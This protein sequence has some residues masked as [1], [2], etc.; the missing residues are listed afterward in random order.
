MGHFCLNNGLGLRDTL[1]RL[2]TLVIRREK[3]FRTHTEL[4]Y[5]HLLPFL[6][7]FGHSSRGPC[8]PLIQPSSRHGLHLCSG[9]ATFPNKQH[10][11]PGICT[12]P[13][14]QGIVLHGTRE[15][16]TCRG[17]EAAVPVS[18]TQLCLKKTQKLQNPAHRPLQE[19]L[20]HSSSTALPGGPQRAPSSPGTPVHSPWL[21]PFRQ[22][23]FPSTLQTPQGSV[24]ILTQES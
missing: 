6:H 5:L 18:K 22:Q 17:G 15:S 4:P 8:S 23:G 20:L 9:T 1:C 12:S 14:R 10:E 21:L 7:G 19:P 24:F 16:T 3:A 13:P 2:C 11:A